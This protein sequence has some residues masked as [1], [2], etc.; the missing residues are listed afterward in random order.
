M[1]FSLCQGPCPAVS[2]NLKLC[3][4]LR[5]QLK[6][7]SWGYL[8]SRWTRLRVRWPGWSL[9][10]AED[11]D[12]DI[13]PALGGL[14]CALHPTWR[15]CDHQSQDLGVGGHE[16]LKSMP[17]GGGA[18]VPWQEPSH[19]LH[20]ASHAS[21]GASLHPQSHGQGTWRTLNILTN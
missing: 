6:A 2:Q 14:L 20:T 21:L 4:F 9:D 3:C 15:W 11:K 7:T 13:I 18:G 17:W 12:S 19:C 1:H 8:R 16:V 5:H 10:P